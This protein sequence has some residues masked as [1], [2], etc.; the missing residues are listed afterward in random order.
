MRLRFTALPSAFLMLQP[1]RL[2]SRLLGRRKTVNSRL[3]LRR[4]LRYTASNSARRTN[5]QARGKSNRSGS[6]ARETMAALLAA[7][8]EDFSSSLALHPGTKSMLLVAGP[9]VGLKSAFRQRSFSCL[10]WNLLVKAT[11]PIL[12]AVR[13]P[14]ERGWSPMRPGALP[15][16]LHRA[17]A[18]IADLFETT[19]LDEHASRV[20][21]STA[22]TRAPRFWSAPRSSNTPYGNR[23]L[24]HGWVRGASGTVNFVALDRFPYALT[25]EIKHYLKWTGIRLHV[26]VKF[27]EK[28]A[29]AVRK[30]ILERTRQ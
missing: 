6:D 20:K 26:Q 15:R 29:N 19:S 17:R 2:V 24:L 4:P 18:R 14:R 21:E 9:D 3:D 8:R 16:P 30:E 13:I 1:N 12:M 23:T 11:R 7:P 10:P 5:R 22:Y 28:N 27:V 25:A